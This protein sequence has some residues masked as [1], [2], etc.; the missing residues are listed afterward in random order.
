VTVITYSQMCN[1][2]LAGCR[3]AGEEGISV[4]VI[5]LRT[6]KRWTWKQLPRR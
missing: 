6:L 3:K 4:E 2:L 1:S 5:D